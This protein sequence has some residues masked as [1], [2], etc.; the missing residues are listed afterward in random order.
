M[1][2]KEG[3]LYYQG[4]PPQ[5]SDCGAFMLL[6]TTASGDSCAD[7]NNKAVILLLVLVFSEYVTLSREN[8][9]EE[10]RP[11]W[12]SPVLAVSCLSFQN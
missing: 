4:S 1:H 12:R 5:C 10:T 6:P 2:R 7:G 9:K 3:Q 8:M 11:G